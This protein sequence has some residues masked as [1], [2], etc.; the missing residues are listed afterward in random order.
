MGCQLVQPDGAEGGLEMLADLLGIVLDGQ[1]LTAD[2]ILLDPDIEKF[3]HSQLAGH[4][5]GT[6]IPRWTANCC[7]LSGKDTLR[8]L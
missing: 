5:V 6:G 8:R 7:S 3:S 2:E 4:L 1:G